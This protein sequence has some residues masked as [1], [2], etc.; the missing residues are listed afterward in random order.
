MNQHLYISNLL[1]FINAN[2]QFFLETVAPNPNNLG[3][4]ISQDAPK[5]I[6]DLLGD[7]YELVPVSA[8]SANLKKD[9]NNNILFV[10]FADSFVQKDTDCYAIAIAISPENNIRLFTYEKGQHYIDGSPAYFVGEFDDKCSHKN[11]GTT[12]EFS[13]AQF[14]GKIV[15]QL[16]K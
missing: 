9:S 15:E 2:K 10:Q 4:F 6:C 1:K 7:K 11:Y 13:I 8:I 12:R 14:C 5:R 16:N 3:Y